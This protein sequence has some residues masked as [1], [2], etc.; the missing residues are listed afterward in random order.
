MTSYNK[1]SCIGYLSYLSGQIAQAIAMFAGREFVIADD[2]QF[3][4]KDVLDHR[5]VMDPQA[6]FSGQTA[7]GVVEEILKNT[8]VPT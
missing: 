6:R 5:I 3:L 1:I 7:A 2:V 8:R 4:V